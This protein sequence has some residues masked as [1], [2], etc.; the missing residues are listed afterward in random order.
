MSLR[1]D[2]TIGVGA[3]ALGSGG[4]GLQIVYDGMSLA[5][6]GFNILLVLCV[7]VLVVYRIVAAER[8]RRRDGGE[9]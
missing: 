4:L 1:S 9:K 8:T 5:L 7:T 3:G 2:T 6:M